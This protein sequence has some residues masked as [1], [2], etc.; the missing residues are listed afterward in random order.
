MKVFWEQVG[1]LLPVYRLAGLGFNDDEI[2][3]KLNLSPLKVQSCV[4]W[5]L[6]FLGL[7]SR[8]ELVQ[9]ASAA[10][11]ALYPAREE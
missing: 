4:T 7:T 3:G 11:M 9:Y 10:P 2:A 1:F 6:R 8:N 5:L